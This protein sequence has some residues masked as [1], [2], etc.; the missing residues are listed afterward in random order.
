MLC[1]IGYEVVAATSGEHA[2]KVLAETQS[3]INMAV[4][5]MQMHGLSGIETLCKIR[6]ALPG[7]PAVLMSG[8]DRSYFGF[9]LERPSDSVLLKKPFKLACLKRA[10]CLD[11][12]P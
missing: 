5:D 3:V 2:L 10:M 8:R 12:S 1:G 11:C 4:V 9:K 7:V 6:E